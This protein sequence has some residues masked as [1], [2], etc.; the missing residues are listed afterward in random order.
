ML[1][2]E[3][4]YLIVFTKKIRFYQRRFKIFNYFPYFDPPRTWGLYF[5]GIVVLMVQPQYKLFS[6]SAI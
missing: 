3:Y 6:Y 2:L 4:I 5:P 1:F